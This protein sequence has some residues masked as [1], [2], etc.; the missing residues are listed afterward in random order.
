MPWTSRS[1][2]SRKYRTP[3]SMT[4]VSVRSTSHRGDEERQRGRQPRPRPA[5]REERA[6]VRGRRA[7]RRRAAPAVSAAGSARRRRV[8]R[9]RLGL[10]GAARPARPRAPPAR[11]AGSAAAARP[12]PP[13]VPR[14]RPRRPV[15][16]SDAA[17]SAQSGSVAGC[18]RSF[19]RS[20]CTRAPAAMAIV[21][22][23]ARRGDVAQRRDDVASVRRHLVLLVTV[24]EV[25]VELTD[26]R[27][28]QFVQFRD[29]LVD[30]RRGCRTGP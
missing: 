11:P 5:D 14:P 18:L 15:R 16:P 10:G 20:L 17:G 4:G 13:P 21:R 29:V 19:A 1:N 30:A 8:G 26:A 25:E 9:G 27:G 6:E 12:R 24:H 2:G 3:T 22:R 23:S 7:S 28:G